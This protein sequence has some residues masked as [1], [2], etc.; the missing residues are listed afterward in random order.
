MD[1]IFKMLL[2][3]FPSQVLS[4]RPPFR[5]SCVLQWYPIGYSLVQ[6]GPRLWARGFS[7]HRAAPSMN[8]DSHVGGDRAVMRGE[9]ASCSA[10]GLGFVATCSAAPLPAPLSTLEVS[11][12]KSPFVLEAKMGGGSVYSDR[13]STIQNF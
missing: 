2:Q 5:V 10:W 4:L 11:L 13:C 8:A 6:V 3:G 9:G 12:A 1:D 7:S